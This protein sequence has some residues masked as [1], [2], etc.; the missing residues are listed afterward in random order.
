MYKRKTYLSDYDNRINT[1]SSINKF[2]Y[3]WIFIFWQYNTKTIKKITTFNFDS[4]QISIAQVHVY[5]NNSKRKLDPP[6]H[7]AATLIRFFFVVAV[8]MAFLIYSISLWRSIYSLLFYGVRFDAAPATFRWWFRV[9]GC[10][11]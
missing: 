1:T 11:Q 8:E 9:S 6:F 3:K 10:S 5:D 4:L 7:K 2:Q